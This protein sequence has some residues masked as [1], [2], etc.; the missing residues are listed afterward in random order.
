[1][2]EN[3]DR[4]NGTT[5][6]TG[7]TCVLE[8][9]RYFPRQLITPAELTLEQDYFR[10]R[11]RL[12]NRF[13]HGWGVVCGARVCPVPRKDDDGYEPWKV[14]VQRGYLLDPYGNDILLSRPRVFDLRTRCLTVV[15]GEPCTNEEGDPWCRDDYERPRPQNAPLYVAVRYREFRRRP[16]RVQPAGCGCDD[17]SCE[18]SRWCDGYEICALPKCPQPRP[19]AVRQKPAREERWTDPTGRVVVIDRPDYVPFPSKEEP[20]MST[21]DC[22]ECPTDPWVVLAR[23]EVDG[24]G[25]IEKIDNCDCRRIVVSH[26]HTWLTYPSGTLSIEDV[27]GGPLVPGGTTRLEI[28][29][30]GFTEGLV[31]RLG[32]GTTVKTVEVEE[33]RALLDVSVAEEAAEGPRSLILQRPDC[34]TVSASDVVDVVCPEQGADE[35]EEDD[36]GGTA[37]DRRRP[38]RKTGR[39]RVKKASRRT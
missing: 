34:T 4:S 2:M 25:Q 6:E 20:G 33:G 5:C 21:P 19:A 1:M 17:S 23:V 15:T 13:L 39:R 27:A 28:R 32:E 10:E 30:S 35:E 29:G 3:W 16:V 9:P 8:R 22:P 18:D 36:E 14:C 12:H 37:E 38:A 11:L 26:A 24:A 7:D 31:A